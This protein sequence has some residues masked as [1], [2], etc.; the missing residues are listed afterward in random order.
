MPIIESTYKPNWF[1]RNAHIN[2]VL[3]SIGRKAPVLNFM[4]ERIETPDGDFI[5]VDW[6]KNSFEPLVLRN[7]PSHF[8]SKLKVENSKLLIAVSGL[9]GNS[10][11]TYMRGIMSIFS[12][13]G[14]YCVSL[15]HRSCSG[16]DNRLLNTY[17]S[18]FTDD[19]RYFM[20]RL[21]K[22]NYYQEIIIVGYS[23]GGNIVMKFCGEEGDKINPK[24]KKV[25]AIS[26]PAELG[27]SAKYFER[28]DNFAYMQKF[29]WT[30][31]KKA[32]I[33]D[34][35]F[36]GSFDLKKVLTAKTFNDFDENFTA[37]TFGFKSAEDYYT[38][39]S[40]KPFFEKIKI[41]ALL[42]I[43]KDDTFVSPE[44]Y[45][46]QFAEQSKTFHFLAPDYGGH[47]GFMPTDS[48]QT[49]WVERE[50]LKFAEMK[51]L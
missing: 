5:D 14:Y 34:Q 9:E 10:R 37:P 1:Y 21:E 49:L 13:N 38:Q 24:I 6:V 51:F 15:H 47:C 36:P 12:K 40:C 41:P 7:E 16:E 45:P 17:H 19:L 43:A 25:I 20:E 48:N 28:S 3:G 26:V 42:I 39:A 50:A 22:E 46:F 27:S 23:L 44:S 32:K 33:K 4:R 2:T 30:L 18:G 11:K 35:K 8:K 31:K 29:F